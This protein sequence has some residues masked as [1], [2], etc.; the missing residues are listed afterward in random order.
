METLF[1]MDHCKVV[2]SGKDVYNKILKFTTKK[3]EYEW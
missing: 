1:V 2:L 3:Q